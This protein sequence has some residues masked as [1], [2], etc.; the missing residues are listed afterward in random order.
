MG[1][2]KINARSFSKSSDLTGHIYRDFKTRS[3]VNIYQTFTMYEFLSVQLKAASYQWQNLVH[4]GF[5]FL[6][7]WPFLF[8]WKQR[9]NMFYV[10]S[11]YNKIRY[12]EW[13]LFPR[14]SNLLALKRQILLMCVKKGQSSYLLFTSTTCTTCIIETWCSDE[15]MMKYIIN[16]HI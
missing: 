2:D 11:L 8:Q 10:I 1:I 13:R 16:I 3:I 4:V 6:N 5:S 12:F 14:P 7:T 15:Y 9:R